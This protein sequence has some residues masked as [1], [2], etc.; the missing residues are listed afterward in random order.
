MRIDAVEILFELKLVMIRSSVSTGNSIR[1]PGGADTVF[2]GGSWIGSRD[3]TEIL[4]M[5]APWP[6]IKRLQPN[7]EEEGG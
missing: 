7:H 3:I 1:R 2:D 6:H 4:S 5:H